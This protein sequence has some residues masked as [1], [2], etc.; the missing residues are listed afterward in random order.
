MKTSPAL[1]G[2]VYREWC[3]Q[4][5]FLLR[6]GV[7]VAHLDSHHHVHTL[8]F[9]FP[10]IKAVQRR[11]GIRKVRLT[12]NVYRPHERPGRAK[13]IAKVMFN[14]LLRNAYATATTVAFTEFGTFYDLLQSR[15]CQTLDPIEAMVH[16]G[17]SAMDDA[18]ESD[19]LE[20]P[21]LELVNPAARLISYDE[22]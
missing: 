8:P 6:K 9:L 21:W 17:G 3:A 13:R 7:Q 16:P 20:R 14:W 19:L 11:F 10:V 2:A 5:S 22:L 4:V 18:R 15:E 12:K 1:L